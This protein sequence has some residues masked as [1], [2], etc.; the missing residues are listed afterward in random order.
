MEGLAVDPVSWPWTSP[1]QLIDTQS[2]SNH[3]LGDMTH[4]LSIPPTSCQSWVL[5]HSIMSTY[6]QRFPSVIQQTLWLL[7]SGGFDCA[8]SLSSRTFFFFFDYSHR[9][10]AGWIQ[11][12]L[13]TWFHVRSWYVWLLLPLSDNPGYRLPI[14][15]FGSPHSNLS[16]PRCVV[17]VRNIPRTASRL[18][19]ICSLQ[20]TKREQPISF[21]IRAWRITEQTQPSVRSEGTG[22]PMHRRSCLCSI[23][24]LLAVGHLRLLV[25][26][27]SIEKT[28]S[29]DENYC[30][31]CKRTQ[32]PRTFGL[33][34]WATIILPP[35][36][37]NA[38]VMGWHRTKCKTKGDESP[39]WHDSGWQWAVTFRGRMVE[40][41]PR[42]AHLAI[43]HERFNRILEYHISL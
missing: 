23:P 24:I 15:L 26:S 31:W 27:C 40:I 3:A 14:M 21:L 42:F 36:L 10:R 17:L 29:V 8:C 33:L 19:L 4:E 37:I 35:W 41:S 38:I 7:Y 28:E 30:L 5:M 12:W 43:S 25:S 9:L 16:L 20:P 32:F 18:T 39:Q 13:P 34:E 2:E 6:R 22:S 1:N 11:F